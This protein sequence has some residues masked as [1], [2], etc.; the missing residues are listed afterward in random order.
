M[1]MSEVVFE[2]HEY[3]NSVKRKFQQP[4][5]QRTGSHT[6]PFAEMGACL[7]LS[8]TPQFSLEKALFLNCAVR[9]MGKK[10]W[11]KNYVPSETNLYCNRL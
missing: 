8:S 9:R 10:Y 5:R 4:L 6:F 1:S 3:S 7:L 2:K 11:H